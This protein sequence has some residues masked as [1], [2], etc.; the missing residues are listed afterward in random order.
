MTKPKYGGDEVPCEVSI[1]RFNGET[2]ITIQL[3]VKEPTGGTRRMLATLAAADFALA[4]TGRGG[5][6][7]RLCEWLPSRKPPKEK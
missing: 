5:V 4:L 3:T 2:D 7:G 6:M 1:T